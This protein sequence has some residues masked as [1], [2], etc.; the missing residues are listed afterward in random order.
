MVKVD[1]SHLLEQREKAGNVL[2]LHKG[3]KA[4]LFKTLAQLR[5]VTKFHLCT[6]WKLTVISAVHWG[7]RCPLDVSTE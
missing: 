1:L 6:E 5:S 7:Q 3:I 2:P 4:H